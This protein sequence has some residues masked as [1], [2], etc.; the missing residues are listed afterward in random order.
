MNL[1]YIAIRTLTYPFSILPFRAIH[2][3]GKGLGTLAYFVMTKYRKRTLSNLALAGIHP[4]KK[5]ARKAFQNLAI[6]CLEYPKF[7]RLKQSGK[8]IHCEN[9]EIAQKLIDAGTGVIFFCGHQANWELLFFEGTERM[10]GV[11]IGRPIKNKALYD[12][13]VAIREKF[14]GKII[15]PK[16]G[17]KEGLRALRQGKFLGIVG[18]QG[19][20]ES[21]YAF[22]FFGKRAWTTPLPAILSYRTGCPIMTATIRREKGKYLI[23]YSDPIW[24]NKEEK[25]ESEIHRMMKSA[26]AILEEDIEKRPGQWL[27]QHNRWKQETPLNVY[28]RFRWDTILIILPQNFDL[29]V[30]A[31]FRE[32][33]PQAFI[34]LLVP[35]GTE[36][37]LDDVEVMTYENESDLFIT[38]YRFKLVFNFT[39]VSA[40]HPHFLKQSAFK[41]LDL[42][43]LKKAAREHL[44]PG[45]PLP[46]LLK[47]ALTRPNTLW[48]QL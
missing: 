35:K 32:I 43:G 15:T 26:L 30:L 14:G 33:Y 16:Q 24:P 23:H 18:D 21:P 46:L 37:P 31:T 7:S 9:P 12:W 4:L 40:L 19:M 34:T 10:P 6:T 48:S 42:K 39:A 45:D 5:T 38:D 36:V 3:L 8:I 20:P 41:V 11:A 2:L 17:L 28:Y 25:L 22:D 44:H 29:S 47:K 13:V 27:W 1:S